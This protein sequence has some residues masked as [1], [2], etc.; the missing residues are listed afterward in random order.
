MSDDAA[1]FVLDDASGL[2]VP[3]APKARKDVV[4]WDDLNALNVPFEYSA[5]SHDLLT[6]LA[7]LVAQGIN[8]PRLL[9]VDASGALKVGARINAVTRL[10]APLAAAATQAMVEDTSSF[11]PGD[12][13]SIVAN[14]APNSVC[15][16]VVVKSIDDATN[17]QFVATCS[18]LSFSVGDYVIGEQVANI[19]RI[20]E[21]VALQT[22]RVAVAPGVGNPPDQQILATNTAYNRLRWAVDPERSYDWNNTVSGAAG[23]QASITTSSFGVGFASECAMLEGAIENISGALVALYFE[24]WN[25]AGG[26]GTRVLR[27]PMYVQNN[28]AEKFTLVPLHYR[29]T[30][31][32]FWTWR[33][34]RAVANVLGH[35][36][37]AG[38]VEQ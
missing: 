1:S 31:N 15:T 32:G 27:V 30:D 2:F 4:P 6:S 17:M 18:A 22:V 13:V 7:V 25:G 9:T 33:M 24:L 8:R 19:R 29:S 3:S 11:F 20:Y 14:G 28:V 26:T 21:S 36:S 37:I 12:H 16:D 10:T 34:D 38:Y 23:V 35:L 5:I